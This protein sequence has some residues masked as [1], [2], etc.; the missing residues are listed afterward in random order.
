MLNVKFQI[1][2]VKMG[3]WMN[4][5]RLPRVQ[6]NMLTT[7]KNI[8]FPLSKTYP[9]C[10]KS[11]LSPMVVADWD[12]NLMSVQA[13]ESWGKWRLSLEFA[14]QRRNAQCQDDF[15]YTSWWK[16]VFVYRLKQKSKCT[17]WNARVWGGKGWWE[18]SGESTLCTVDV[19]FGSFVWKE[20]H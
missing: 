20:I 12:L 9:P 1:P 18:V 4:T 17:W 11:A 10:Y 19:R 8:L 13:C 7:S 14:R 2:D 16:R 15:N 3:W 6:C 5:D